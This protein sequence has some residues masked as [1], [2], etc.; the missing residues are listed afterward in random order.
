MLIIKYIQNFSTS[1]VLH[2]GTHPVFCTTG[3]AE[4]LTTMR[5]R[6]QAVSP[7][8]VCLRVV[9]IPIA[10]SPPASAAHSGEFWSQQTT[11]P[12]PPPIFPFLPP[13]SIGKWSVTTY[14]K[15]NKR[16]ELVVHT[17]GFMGC[18]VHNITSRV[19]KIGLYTVFPAC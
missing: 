9:A 18:Q 10:P 5:A 4:V 2:A 15:K 1:A 11:L 19:F 8:L 6:P 17:L 3:A 13:Q 16:G 12:H 7:D 14:L